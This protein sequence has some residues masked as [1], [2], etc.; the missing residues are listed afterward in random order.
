M[1]IKSNY[2]FILID[3]FIVERAFSLLALAYMK[4]LEEL[5]FLNHKLLLTINFLIS[6]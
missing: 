3:I 2:V 5:Y 4:N 6:Y 1:H